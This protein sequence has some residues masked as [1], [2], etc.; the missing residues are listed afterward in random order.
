MSRESEIKTRE[1]ST[2]PV[3]GEHDGKFF[4]QEVILHDDEI[5]RIARRV[6]ELLKENAEQDTERTS[7]ALDSA[8]K[9]LAPPEN[10]S[11][12]GPPDSWRSRC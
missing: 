2:H 9:P 10:P 6:V 12:V 5:E 4:W 8:S 7:D 1:L 3:P 11:Y